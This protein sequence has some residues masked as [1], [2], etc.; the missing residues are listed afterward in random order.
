M[1]RFT[2]SKTLNINRRKNHANINHPEFH[3]QTRMNLTF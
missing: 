1:D 3:A 2:L